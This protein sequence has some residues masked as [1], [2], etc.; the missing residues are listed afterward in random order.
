MGV[1]HGWRAAIGRFDLFLVDWGLW[2]GDR[3]LV[4]CRGWASRI[5]GLGGAILNA[6]QTRYA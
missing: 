2:I 1:G 5:L 4:V 6:G 3:R